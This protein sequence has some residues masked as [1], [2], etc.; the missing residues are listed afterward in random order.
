[1]PE[2]TEAHRTQNAELE[3]ATSASRIELGQR[4]IPTTGLGDE[5]ERTSMTMVKTAHEETA[6]VATQ[7]STSI[8]RNKEQG[9][10]APLRDN[11]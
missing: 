3:R 8:V 6:C 2:K 7:D 5:R 10:R 1:M 9:K 11:Q 4:T